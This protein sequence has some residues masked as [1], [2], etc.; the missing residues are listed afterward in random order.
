M[1]FEGKKF[2]NREEIG[3]L[4]YSCHLSH[5]LQPSI[6]NSQISNLNMEGIIYGYKNT[7]SGS[8]EVLDAGG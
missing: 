1:S 4:F 8:Q 5:N 7:G 2:E 3:D 6:L